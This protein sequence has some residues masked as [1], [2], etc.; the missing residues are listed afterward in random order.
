VV[1][2]F[3]HTAIL[4]ELGHTLGLDHGHTADHF[5]ALPRAWDSFEFSVMTYRTAVGNPAAGIRSEAWGNPQS[6]MM[7]DIRALQYL[8]GADYTTNAGATRYSWD[9][10]TGRTF[11]DGALALAPGANRILLTIW[12][13]GGYDTYNLSNYSTDLVVSLYPGSASTLSAVQLA[14]LDQTRAGG[15]ARGNVF[16]ALQ[17]G[18]DPRSLIEAAIGGSG[19]DFIVGNAGPNNLYGNAG[20]DRLVG[21]PDNDRLFGQTG[22]DLL[23]GQTGSDRLTGGVGA[24]ALIGGADADLFDFNSAAE[25]RPGARDVI[26]GGDQTGAFEAAGPAWGDRIDVFHIDAN[27]LAPGNQ[28]FVFGTAT[29]IG[30][31]YAVDVG[32]ATVI[33]GNV[34]GDPAPEFELVIGDGAVRASAYTLFDFIL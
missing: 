23:R 26:V 9:P 21:G 8:Y 28:A 14:D 13:G 4:H 5:G 15:E 30:R 12:D 11:I 16:N 32:T 34:D 33:R 24:D 19:N 18:G 27:V 6:Y 10:A 1:G 17:V 25:S 7:L 2:N 22:D 29:G 20:H 3:D 31:L